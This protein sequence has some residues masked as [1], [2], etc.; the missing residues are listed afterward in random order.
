MEKVPVALNF[1]SGERG[2]P[3]GASAAS[4]HAAERCPDAGA[5]EEVPGGPGSKVAG[6]VALDSPGSNLAGSE[7]QA[8]SGD[9]AKR[10]G[11]GDAGNTGAL[12]SEGIDEL[13][14]A[15]PDCLDVR[16]GA[17]VAPLHG[18]KLDGAG[19]G[20]GEAGAMDDISLVEVSP[21][22]ASSNFDA[23]RLIGGSSTVE[24]S[25]PLEESGARGCEPEARGTPATMGFPNCDGFEVGV[26]TKDEVDGRIGLAEGELELRA[27]GD[28]AVEEVAD[29]SVLCDE[30]VEG[31]DTNLEQG[32]DRM[33][34]SLDDSEPSDGSTTQDSDTDVD[35]ESS[36]SSSEEQDVGYGAHITRVGQAIQKVARENSTAG[37][38][39]SDR[40][41]SVS[42]SSLV[43]ASGAAMLPHPAKVLTGGEDAYFI[44]HDGWFG[45]ADGVGQWSFEGINAGLYARE[46]MDS[47]KR[48]VESQGASEISTEEVLAKAA[49]E[50]R[51]PGSSTVLVAHFDGQVLHASNI[52]DSGFL[53]VRNGEI[54]KKSNP[55]TY[56]FNFPLQ[57]EKGDD[58]LKLV[59]KYTIDLQEGDVIVT[60]TDGLFDNVYEEE[61]AAIVSKSLEAELKPT[62]IAEFLAARAKEV[63]RCGF[64]SSPF[65]DAARDAGYLGYSGGKLDDVAVVVSIVRKSEV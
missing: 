26:E 19:M 41:T 58:P 38:K 12:R 16:L 28:D 49:D 39:S 33:E 18:R 17:P 52:G 31:M 51:S 29:S 2:S 21:S 54:Y 48:F 61:V 9:A 55:M 40:M 24:G 8:A 15:D 27:D 14:S 65:S 44:A 4:L 1:R 45:V 50:A 23:T 57:I 64:G 46:L 47:C 22:D 13:E 11:G 6:A 62:E 32:V 30:R 42:S 43:L 59:Q 60:A 3:P 35:T 20:S 56:G 7:G 53:V 37:M 63:G 5:A 10:P 25:G 36:G 34:T